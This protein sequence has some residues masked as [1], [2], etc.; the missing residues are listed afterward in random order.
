MVR[1][2]HALLCTFYLIAIWFQDAGY[3]TLYKAFHGIKVWWFE[4]PLV[5][6]QCVFGQS[7]HILVLID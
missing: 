1:D 3:H 6:I 2:G 7:G 5:S 4:G